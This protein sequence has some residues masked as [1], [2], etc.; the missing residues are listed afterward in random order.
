MTEWVHEKGLPSGKYALNVDY[1]SSNWLYQ[2][3]HVSTGLVH[4]LL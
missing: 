1:S 3:T 4:R 2:M